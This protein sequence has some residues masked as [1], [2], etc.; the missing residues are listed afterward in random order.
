MP[1]IPSNTISTVTAKP[2]KGATFSPG[3]YSPGAAIAAGAGVI[4]TAIDLE[5]KKAQ[6]KAGKG[7]DRI[8]AIQNMNDQFN[9]TTRMHDQAAD[10]RARADANAYQ[11]GA[12]R[13]INAA[14]T[15][16]GPNGERVPALIDTPYVRG[17]GDGTPE[18][19]AYTATAEYISRFRDN[20]TYNGL[21]ERARKYVDEGWDR[22]VSPYLQKAL[23]KQVADVERYN[24]QAGASLAQSL[25]KAATDS[26]KISDLKMHL[27]QSKDAVNAMASMAM[28]GKYGS[29]IVENGNILDPRFSDPT[30]M[31]AWRGLR[32]DAQ[33]KISFDIASRNI[34]EAI[35]SDDDAEA[36][37]MFET[38]EFML[39]QDDGEEGSDF[40]APEQETKLKTMV[41]NG[42]DARKRKKVAE[43]NQLKSDMKDVAAKMV[44]GVDTEEDKRFYVNGLMKMERG[45]A[46]AL[47]KQGEED[48]RAMSVGD[49]TDRMK[50]VIENGSDPAK[51]EGEIDSIIGAEQDPIARYDLEQAKKKL[52][53]ETFG[54]GNKADPV[55]YDN[56][57]NYLTYGYAPSGRAN[58]R[59]EE[60]L[61]EVTPSQGLERARLL[62]KEGKISAS[63]FRTAV[64]T[65]KANNVEGEIR[66]PWYNQTREQA[67]SSFKRF[68][69]RF[70]I[71]PADIIKK[72][73]MYIDPSTGMLKPGKNIEDG[74]TVDVPWSARNGHLE[75]DA[76]REFISTY[77][78]VARYISIADDPDKFWKEFDSIVDKKPAFWRL[79]NSCQI[80]V[81]RSV[82]GKVRYAA[83]VS[84]I[85]AA[86]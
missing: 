41:A 1:T 14:F 45:D 80:S 62:R 30:M 83:A 23:D 86:Q 57:M 26:Y 82:S 68:S 5:G 32:E 79:K 61:E 27:E 33:R 63:Q 66:P 50:A 34:S 64:N 10:R 29:K 55:Y 19:G 3:I 2:R 51:I 56:L 60:I 48:A 6:D 78:D 43:Y 74:Y 85:D 37:K 7:R 69:E 49:R 84:L 8:R 52:L 44:L 53:G 36:E 4:G 71:D 13:A 59:G 54:S 76:L 12:S 11:A 65:L 72:G 47:M 17:N 77:N 75:E 35:V 22:M 38:A 58:E 67:Q 40:F 81:M 18:K 70:G 28:V 16:Y 31:T 24:V 15:G 21:S 73:M 25:Y 39:S 9:L 20:D 46:A 42:R